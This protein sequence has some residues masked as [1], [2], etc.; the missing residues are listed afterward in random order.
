MVSSKSASAPRAAVAVALIAGAVHTEAF[1][2]GGGVVGPSSL[3]QGGRASLVR[4]REHAGFAAADSIFASPSSASSP[5]R[6]CG[7]SAERAFGG[8]VLGRASP[9]SLLS[10]S[11]SSAAPERD[12]VVATDGSGKGMKATDYFKP[13]VEG[14]ILESTGSQRAIVGG[15]FVLLAAM[16]LKG[17]AG[18]DWSEP[19]SLLAG[20]AAFLVGYEFADFGSG[21]YHWSMDNYGDKNTPI[22]G[23]QIEAFQ[24]SNGPCCVPHPFLSRARESSIYNFRSGASGSFPANLTG[25]LGLCRPPNKTQTLLLLP[26]QK[27]QRLLPL[28]GL[29]GLLLLLL[30][31]LLL[32]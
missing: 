11:M 7:S 27:Q 28:L 4:G 18:L 17:L 6:R 24:V 21:V 10:L 15:A 32:Q 29:L 26:M 30:L 25:A 9:S 23:T 8:R 16:A 3:L 1:A 31:L 20:A 19:S 5:L 22:F 13:L 12:D 2:S 14:D